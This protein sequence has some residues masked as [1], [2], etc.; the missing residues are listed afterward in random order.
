MQER[1]EYEMVH[2]V[3]EPLVQD[4]AELFSLNSIRR[5]LERRNQIEENLERYRQKRKT[6]AVENTPKA[7]T[8]KDDDVVEEYESGDDLGDE[9]VWET[10]DGVENDADIQMEE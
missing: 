5:L 8:E 3:D 2:E 9:G 7:N 4:D 10:A 6:K 1:K